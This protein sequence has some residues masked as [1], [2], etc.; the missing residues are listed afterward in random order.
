MNSYLLALP[1]EEGLS[2]LHHCTDGWIKY[3]CRPGLKKHCYLIHYSAFCA[4]SYMYNTRLLLLTESELLLCT[5]SMAFPDNNL[6]PG[7]TCKDWF[8]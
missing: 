7:F 4:L 6:G 1:A 2:T 8:V 5:E 3:G